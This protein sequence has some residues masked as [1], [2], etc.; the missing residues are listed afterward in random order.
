DIRVRTRVGQ[1]YQGA[2]LF[3]ENGDDQFAGEAAYAKFINCAPAKMLNSA[4]NQNAYVERAQREPYCRG[5][6]IT[7]FGV[8]AGKNFVKTMRSYRFP[9]LWHLES[10]NRYEPVGRKD[11]TLGLRWGLLGENDYPANR[12]V[13]TVA[14]TPTFSL[15]SSQEPVL[16]FVTNYTFQKDKG[17]VS[18]PSNPPICADTGY[19]VRPGL[20]P[21]NYV[22]DGGQVWITGVDAF[23]RTVVHDLL[24]PDGGYDAGIMMTPCAVTQTGGVFRHLPEGQA[25]LASCP[26]AAARTL[27]RGCN[28]TG[29]NY[30]GT[31][32]KNAFADRSGSPA[33]QE[34]ASRWTEKRFDLGKYTANE[35]RGLTYRIEFHATKQTYDHLHKPS[36]GWAID[37]IRVAE[38]AL[39]NDVGVSAIVS[40]P[41][42]RI[43]GPAICSIDGVE[44]DLADCVKTDRPVKNAQTLV[45]VVTNHGLYTQ[46]GINVSVEIHQN[47]APTVIALRKD[48]NVDYV[49]NPDAPLIPITRY[50]L[51]TGFAA[52]DAIPGKLNLE[53]PERNRT[54]V[55]PIEWT[56]T[57]P[58]FYDIIVWTDLNASESESFRFLDENPLNDAFTRT[59]ELRK[60]RSVRVAPAVDVF[61]PKLQWNSCRAVY[62]DAGCLGYLGAPV[63]FSIPVQNV[64]SFPEEFDPSLPR[65]RSF[66]L[67]IDVLREG[68]GVSDLPAPIVLPI[69]DLPAGQAQI[70][71]VPRGWTPRASGVYEVVFRVHH[72]AESVDLPDN[73]RRIKFDVFDNL[74]P[75]PDQNLTTAFVPEA[76]WWFDPKAGTAGAWR[77]S[78][79]GGYGPDL[80]ASLTLLRLQNLRS[81]RNLKIVMNH[82]YDFERQHDGGIVEVG[83]LRNGRIEWRTLH[84]EAGYPDHLSSAAAGDPRIVKR[85]FTGT[86]NGFRN[87]SFDLSQFTEVIRTGAIL[88]EER[89]LDKQNEGLV[90]YP[91]L[92]GTW[93]NDSYETHIVKPRSG[94]GLLFSDKSALFCEIPTDTSALTSVVN[95]PRYNT[96]LLVVDKYRRCQSQI[97]AQSSN[98]NPEPPRYGG[99]AETTKNISRHFTLSNAEPGS[100]LVITFQDWRGLGL[101]RREVGPSTN[102]QPREPREPNAA[103]VA[104]CCDGQGRAVSLVTPPSRQYNDNYRDWTLNVHEIALA[105]LDTS[106]PLSL[107]FSHQV[108]VGTHKASGIHGKGGDTDVLSNHYGWAIDDVRIQM[109]RPGGGLVDLVHENFDDLK[110]HAN[111]SNGCGPNPALPS[112]WNWTGGYVTKMVRTDNGE[113]NHVQTSNRSAWR[114]APQVGQPRM[115]SDSVTGTP[116]TCAVPYSKPPG[117][118]STFSTGRGFCAMNSVDLAHNEEDITFNPNTI[119]KLAHPTPG[120]TAGGAGRYIT[121]VDLKAAV[122]DVRMT[123]D[124]R[125]KLE[126]HQFILAGEFR[127]QQLSCARVEV[128]T[129]GGATWE[130]QVPT[131]ARRGNGLSLATG[132]T[133]WVDKTSPSLAVHS[134]CAGR[135]G[136][137]EFNSPFGFPAHGVF[138]D[139]GTACLDLRCHFTY[140][141]SAY[142]GKE[143][144]VGWHVGF[145][146]AATTIGSQFAAGETQ[147][148]P[149]FLHVTN[150][151]VT[152]S[153]L[154]ASDLLLRFRA[155]SDSSV[156]GRG[157][158]I[159]DVRVIGVK[160]LVNAASNVVAP[161]PTKFYRS[162]VALPVEIDAINKGQQTLR[163][164]RLTVRIEN[165]DAFGN[166]DP[167]T[168]R[169]FAGTL[170]QFRACDGRTF[171]E[172]VIPVST[173]YRLCEFREGAVFEAMSAPTKGG[174]D[175]VITTFIEHRQ[176]RPRTGEDFEMLVG[177]N[178]PPA[179]VVP[180]RQFVTE[181]A[182]A[183]TAIEPKPSA[184]NLSRKEPFEFEVD[185]RNDGISEIRIQELYAVI[186]GPL[187]HGGALEN[188]IRVT[189]SDAIRGGSSV[190]RE[191]RE[192]RTFAWSI[193]FATLEHHRHGIYRITAT[194]VFENGQRSL[195]TTFYLGKEPFRALVLVEDGDASLSC[196]DNAWC[197]RN[198]GDRVDGPAH[199][200]GRPPN[201]GDG[202]T[203][204]PTL[205]APS[206]TTQVSHTPDHAFHFPLHSY[207]IMK[208]G[209]GAEPPKPTEDCGV[210][211]RDPCTPVY[212][213][214][215][216]PFLDAKVFVGPD[217][218]AGL[219]SFFERRKS[220]VHDVSLHV[221]GYDSSNQLVTLESIRAADIDDLFGAETAGFAI[222]HFVSRSIS[223]S[224]AVREARAVPG[225]EK[226][227]IA[228]VVAIQQREVFSGWWIDDL[229]IGPYGATLYRDEESFIT[230]NVDKTFRFVMRNAG[231]VRDAYAFHFA[232]ADMR[233]AVLPAA[234]NVTILDPKGRILAQTGL[235]VSR[236][237][238]PP[239]RER[240]RLRTIE[241]DPQEEVVLGLRICVPTVANLAGKQGQLPFPVVA[242]SETDNY[243]RSE[244]KLT[245]NYQYL[246]WPNLVVE[247]PRLS[248]EDASLPP[249]QPRAV[250]VTIRNKGLLEARGVTLD[251][252]DRNPDAPQDLRMLDGT[253][254]PVI[255]IIP[256]D[257]SRTLTLR[258]TPLAPGQHDLTAIVDLANAI[259]ELSEDDNVA[260]TRV[261]VLK[262]AFPDLKVEIRA[263]NEQP[264]V[265]DAVWLDAAITN[266]GGVAATSVRVSLKVGA[267]DLVSSLDGSPF[268][269]RSIE[270][271]ETVHVNRTWR[272][273]FPGKTVVFASAIPLS[274]IRERVD[275]QGDNLRALPVLVRSLG[276]DVAWRDALIS[277]KPGAAP[278]AQILLSNGGE[279]SD[280]FD[281]RIEGPPG[282][283]GFVYQDNVRVTSVTLANGT[284]A[285]LTVLIDLPA[286]LEAGNATLRFVARSQNTT[287]SRAGEV[288]L[289]VEPIYALALASGGASLTPGERTLEV[290]L[291]NLGNARDRVTVSA[292]SLPGGW[293]IAPQ[294]VTVDPYG[295]AVVRLRVTT[296]TSAPPAVYELLLVATNEKG[297]SSRAVLA[298]TV[299]ETDV[300]APFFEASSVLGR[301]KTVLTVPVTIRNVG[302]MRG[303]ASLSVAAPPGWTASLARPALALAPGAETEVSLR[304]LVPVNVTR[305][306]S[307]PLVVT[308]AGA[309]SVEK[310]EVSVEVGAADLL[311]E[312]F[313]YAPRVNLKPGLPINVTAVVKNAGRIEA[314]NV[315]VALYVDDSLIGFRTLPRLAA[316]AS[317]TVRFEWIAVAGDH[318]FL[319]IAD[320]NNVHAEGDEQEANNARLE[321]VQVGAEGGLLGAA[322]KAVPGLPAL[323][324]VGVL[325][326][327]AVLGARRRR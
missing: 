218:G 60:V 318:A 184:Y 116:E 285:N 95:D 230:D 191:A 297:V 284:S 193:P 311:I 299:E 94:K 197:G 171:G 185:V 255:P 93:R 128:S 32:V 280:T 274:G 70:V 89:F 155:F 303:E 3:E 159:Q 146:T 203:P 23:G 183:V 249:G 150:I 7:H 83:F 198:E 90:R 200:F 324:L 73:V 134:H 277:A 199:P 74:V 165:V 16:S 44:R 282:V 253:E 28:L 91:Q 75:A 138:L 53:N 149:D 305:G 21:A 187:G 101:I 145:G 58:G 266:N 178:K 117:V 243:T 270:P 103:V 279:A 264:N 295:R 240:D 251:V 164:V 302:N 214:L 38:R 108:A 100:S 40:P 61:D 125:Y 59:V 182:V 278:T 242:V 292:A 181:S 35:L 36:M 157:W 153:V 313:S 105:G 327:A 2:P 10:A 294:T 202:A 231:G 269:I 140:D 175:L 30:D 132:S 174:H 170:S 84:P 232:D 221:L 325:V 319:A 238:C 201:W 298:A 5:W 69:Y 97:N 224:D 195:S 19:K 98:T 210:P 160:H 288:V 17:T 256:V 136:D 234:W 250:E 158:D 275:T 308:A 9:S 29:I 56:P 11:S 261:N 26:N 64:G 220:G 289:A 110:C 215:Y 151:T 263:A 122:G 24:I 225:V 300:L 192:T 260:V 259:V 322:A 227:R 273:L 229:R 233:P 267:T 33:G 161:D 217:G 276:I 63:T 317:E 239:G 162:G 237:L 189:L 163:D 14:R 119:K 43:V 107:V 216:T 92:T 167:A 41:D 156:Q 57:E 118:Y 120:V 245:L 291:R 296:P 1:G 79:D 34:E 133:L 144:L 246:K 65:E 18:N 254:I 206:I 45:A 42:G 115:W 169:T 190:L 4:E 293:A 265:G 47:G 50:S 188:P 268:I 82:S 66:Y 55:F 31:V 131:S 86:S 219:V 177:D 316:G 286:K 78:E 135:G 129:D 287:E 87:D 49:A 8:E 326:A 208:P 141:L 67:E 39:A 114:V 130:P 148:L 211:N 102:T 236:D 281:V 13:W 290:P 248:P 147:R 309:R 209:E 52:A 176:D 99:Y 186:E 257:E 96:D 244:V 262:A 124:A 310:G 226:I 88:F 205:Q 109:K 312:E 12:I 20:N 283:R 112:G 77:F 46:N 68:T 76:P 54:R 223:I 126:M 121:P 137:P 213:T 104:I 301:P 152:A 62:S 271:G 127:S 166:A 80:N 27:L 272:A 113:V 143:V 204:S 168:R 106:K 323:A 247:P 139:S 321:V 306:E 222:R 51:S 241:L 196:I 307:Y 252:E 81:I 212:M 228:F 194:S 15:A 180:S 315:S 173:T 72:P 37:D 235:P 142:K 22:L 258:W 48:P 314:D 6:N 172:D 85:A 304:V 123:F 25:L 207:T 111:P 154:D 179:H 71:T 320:A